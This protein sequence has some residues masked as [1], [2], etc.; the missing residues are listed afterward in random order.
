MHDEEEEFMDHLTQTQDFMDG[1]Q[2]EEEE[3]VTDTTHEQETQE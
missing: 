3:E 2:Q 1:Y